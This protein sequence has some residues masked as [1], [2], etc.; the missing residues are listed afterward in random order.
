MWPS[1]ITA[2]APPAP[3][4][5]AA[6][7]KLAAIAWRTEPPRYSTRSSFSRMAS[8]TRPRVESKYVRASSASTV[9]TPTVSTYST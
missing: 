3:P 2:S 7:M 9:A 5:N 4:Q 8:D 1:D 6:S